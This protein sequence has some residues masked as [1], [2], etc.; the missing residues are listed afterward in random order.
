MGK[1]VSF[2]ISLWLITL[3]LLASGSERF[4]DV[5]VV[6][7]AS[8]APGEHAPNKSHA[9]GIARSMGFN[10][11]HAYGTAL[12]GFAARIPEGRLNGLQHDPRVAYV[13]FDR[14]VALP[15]AGIAAPR[16]CA[17]DPNRPGCGT[18]DGGSEEPVSGDTIPWGISRIGADNGTSSGVGIHVYVLDTGCD[19]NHGDLNTDNGQAL[20]SCTGRR[21]TCRK[22]EDDDHGHGTHVCGTIGALKN[23]SDVVGV[24][25]GVTLHPVKVLSKYGKGSLTDAIAGV[26]WV[27]DRTK[28]LG[29]AT[30]ANMSLTASGEKSGSCSAAGFTGYDA[31]HEALCNAKNVGVVFAVAVGNSGADAKGYI[32]AAY[33]DA[34]ITVSASSSGNDWPSWSNWGND[35]AGWLSSTSAPVALVAPGVSVL[36]TRMG[37]GTTTMS[38][39]SMAAP[40][41]AGA[42]ARFLAD[43]PQPADEN[44]FLNA[45]NHLLGKAES[46]SGFSNSSG[47]PHAEAFLNTR[48]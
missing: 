31:F 20:V 10:A 11:S 28:A 19:T 36:S 16:K 26:D 43:Y 30:V 46:T 37:G 6:L 14:Q 4:V 39:T 21:K 42:V 22:P 5:I 8:T 34:V 38:G 17:Q 27:A 32:P 2:A 44:A 48:P 29:T 1:V 15:R 12:F 41:V 25:P 9:T 35:N 18:D 13:E 23:G 24:A 40:H 3:P 7:E 45:R 33:D 47:H